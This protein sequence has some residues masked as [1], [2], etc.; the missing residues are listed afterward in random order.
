MYFLCAMSCS[1][2]VITSGCNGEVSS[3][4]FLVAYKVRGQMI[5]PKFRRPHKIS[6]L[7]GRSH[8]IH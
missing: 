2:Q 4:I 3:N 6:H 5:E 1:E 8:E 7:K